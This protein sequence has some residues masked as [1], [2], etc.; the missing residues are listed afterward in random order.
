MKIKWVGRL[1]LLGILSCPASLFAQ[2]ALVDSLKIELENH[3][4]EDSARIVLL[5]TLASRL[6]NGEP[7]LARVY[8]KESVYISKKIGHKKGEA[9]ANRLMGAPHFI[10]GNADSAVYYFNKALKIYRDISDKQGEA[11]IAAS[12]GGAYARANKYKEAAVFFFEALKVYE[13]MEI[14]PAVGIMY[15]NIGNL[16]LEQEMFEEALKNYETGTVAYE[17]ASNQRQLAMLYSNTSIVLRELDRYDEALVFIEKGIENAIEYDNRRILGGLLLGKGLIFKHRKEYER[18]KDLF[19]Q[20]L[21]K[22]EELRITSSQIEIVYY[23][24]E[25]EVELGQLV[26]A[27]NRLLSIQEKFDLPNVTLHRLES[28]ALELLA[29]IE[30]SLGNSDQAVQYA[31]DS[32]AI[33]DSL[34][35]QENAAA[36]AELQTIYETE[37]KEQAIELLEAKNET[38]ELKALLAILLGASVILIVSITYWQTSKRKARE[39]ALELQSVQRELENYGV[40]IAE[41]DSFL[42]NVINRL[43]GINKDLKTIESKKELNSVVDSLFQNVKLTEDEDQLFKRI[44]QVNT[45]FFLELDKRFTNLSKNEKRLASLVQM[46]LSNKEIGGILSITPRSVIQ[47][48][49]RLKKKLE[50]AT[51]EDLVSYLKMIGA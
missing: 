20:A 9:A 12:I 15:N 6:Y 31:L 7:D 23:L 18:A 14:Y 47:G 43:R 10:R 35:N 39:R 21:D 48:R 17:K 16:Y 41:K 42:S 40:L 25:V 30:F 2:K 3:I 13:E 26:I 29:N 27:R 4:Q 22:Y 46:D 19:S 34:N 37:K 50:L 8:A 44:E 11:Q 49:Y 51:T 38:A 1:I 45:G 33:S 32:K 24:A 36:I 5:N 28:D